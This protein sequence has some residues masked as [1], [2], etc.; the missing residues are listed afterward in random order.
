MKASDFPGTGNMTEC[1]KDIA[2]KRF[3]QLEINPADHVDKNFTE[4]KRKNWQKLHGKAVAQGVEGMENPANTEE[5]TNAS[6]ITTTDDVAEGGHNTVDATNPDDT[7]VL[8]DCSNM[9]EIF[10]QVL[11][12]D[13]IFVGSQILIQCAL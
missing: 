3:D 7:P 10:I 6:H 9:S 5:P 4:K 1:L 13:R 2:R 8:V 11:S 12:I